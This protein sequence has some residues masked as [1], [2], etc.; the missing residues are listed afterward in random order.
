MKKRD[1]R[2]TLKILDKEKQ[3]KRHYLLLPY[4]EG[5]ENR[6]INH[7][8]NFIKCSDLGPYFDE[9]KIN[10]LH[11]QLVA[12]YHKINLV[13]YHKHKY[14][15]IEKRLQSK[16]ENDLRKGK[17]EEG[18]VLIED[19]RLTAELESFLLQSK[20]TL[21][22]LVS[23][24]N[25]FYRDRGKNPLKKQVTFENKGQNVIKD[26]ERYLKYHYEKKEYLE[27]L[28]KYLK[29]ECITS[30]KF[31]DGSINWLMVVINKRDY[32]AH[33]S[34]S[35]YFAFQIKNVKGKDNYVLPPLLTKKSF[36]YDAVQIFYENLV[37]FTEDFMA[38][39][40]KPYLNKFFSCFTFDRKKRKDNA[41]KWYIIP[42][43]FAK[44]GFGLSTHTP[45]KILKI[46]KAGDIPLEEIEFLKMF[47]YYKSFEERQ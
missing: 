7:T 9:D 45:I 3:I 29:E 30:D 42:T 19:S 35:K 40:L 24:L 1:K 10:L 4:C 44:F 14:Q 15:S 37:T 34:K 16:Y 43:V 47:I 18:I 41:P 6:I 22:I 17:I 2:I 31:D 5:I 20:A 25:I 21:D 12:L 32:I 38:L 39:L 11:E 26:L 28:L 46:I 27:E 23:F 8:L 36:M 13:N 33:F